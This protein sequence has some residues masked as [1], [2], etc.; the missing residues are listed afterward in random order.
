MSAEPLVFAREGRATAVHAP[1]SV[2]DLVAGW[3]A[4]R[5]AMIRHRPD[6]FTRNEWAYLVGFLDGHRLMRPFIDAAGPPAPGAQAQRWLVPHER[7]ALW[8]PNNVSLLGCL[9]LVLISL[10]GARVRVKSG[11]R[12]TDLLAAFVAFA[13]RHATSTALREWLEGVEAQQF[14]RGD[15]RNAKMSEWAQVR[16]FF[17]SDEA[18][19]AVEDLPHRTGS[20]F[21]AFGTHTSEAWW[22]PAAIGD[23][24]AV[25]ALAKVFAVYGQAGCTSPRRVFI[26][27]GSGSDAQALVE[28]LAAAWDSLAAQRVPQAVASEVVLADQLALAQGLR[29]RRLADNAGLL[30]SGPA[31]PAQRLAHMALEV[32][33][34]TLDDAVATSPANLQT[35]GHPFG[36]TPTPDWAAAFARTCGNRLVP[37]ARMHDFGHVWDGVRWWEQLFREIES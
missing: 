5:S 11:S 4:L 14:D 26:V 36:G 28:A 19:A 35:V 23:A 12:S 16:I 22:T 29:A 15:S 3:A 30:A 2:P 34:G 13:R 18:A 10:G 25:S 9:A 27:D 33:W 31:R 21:L 7:V 24:G 20:P 17:G 6:E 32:Q 37:V 8:L 1:I